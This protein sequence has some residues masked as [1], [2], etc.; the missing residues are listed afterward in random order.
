MTLDVLISGGWVVDGT[1][2]PPYPADVAIS[3]E[4][5]VDV[6]RL[7]GATADRV[8]DATG[9]FVTP[10]FID[11]HSHS[12]WTLLSNPTAE[13]AVRQG[14]TTEIVGNCGV[15]LAPVTSANLAATGD[16]L[17]GYVYPGEV[18]WR[19]F[20][21]YLDQVRAIGSSINYAFLVGHNTLRAAAGLATPDSSDDAQQIMERLTAE[22]ME[23]GAIGMSTGLEFDPGRSAPEA[24]IARM[25]RV[26]GRH[27]GIYASHIRNRSFALA[28]AMEEFFR[29]AEAARGRAQVSHLNV[30]ENTGAEDGAWEAAVERIER[31]RREGVDVLT[32]NISMTYGPGL[33]VGILPPW[34]LADGTDVARERLSDP[35]IRQRL[36]TECDRYW[37]FIHRGEW[38]RVRLSVSLQHPEYTG[39]PFPEIAALRGTDAWDVFFDLL[40]DAGPDMAKQLMYGRLYSEQH[41]ADMVSHPLFML[42]VDAMNSTATGPLSERTQLPLTYAGQITY[43]TKFVR[44]T[45]LLRLEEAVRKMTSMP[46]TH[47]GLRERGQLVRGYLADVVVLDLGTLAAPATLERPAVYAE[48]VSHVLVNGAFALDGGDHTGALTGRPLLRA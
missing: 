8:V 22:A 14:V 16:L 30:R 43:L 24:E 25:A 48:G 34:V 1:G 41:L 46:A 4:R 2:N 20:A 37:R 39:M 26:V 13:S 18:T 29:Y 9:C 31:A 10:G 23:A 11:A 12:D 47:F 19:S 32:D 38:D 17:A 7:P 33:M 6:G 40:V 3:G 45:G 27:G 42:A 35:A 21:E 5:I 44:D 36:R 28:D 15:S